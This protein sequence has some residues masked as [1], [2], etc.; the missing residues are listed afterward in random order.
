MTKLVHVAGHTQQSPVFHTDEECW[1][2]DMAATSRKVEKAA[3]QTHYRECGHCANDEPNV[4]E[5]PQNWR[6]VSSE[7]V[8]CWVCGQRFTN[9]ADFDECL[10][11]HD[12]PAYSAD[13]GGA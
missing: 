4:P 9:L 7:P 10:Q 11:S 1:A 5:T 8:R 13:A 3:I 2:L 12:P 6:S